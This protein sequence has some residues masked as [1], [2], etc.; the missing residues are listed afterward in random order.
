MTDDEKTLRAAEAHLKK[1]DPKLRKIIERAGPCQLKVRA[2]GSHFEHLC[3]AIAGQQVTGRAA[4]S[5]FARV[6]ALG[7][8]GRF[9]SP[10]QFLTL[11]EAQL[12]SAGLSR[13]KTAA[14][15]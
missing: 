9:P 15:L 7:D 14:M 5:I 1:V 4:D 12:K 8:G 11:K 6:K 10:A 3:R 2:R 13:Q